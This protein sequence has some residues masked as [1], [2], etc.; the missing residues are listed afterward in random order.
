MNMQRTEAQAA[1]HHLKILY[2]L[3]LSMEVR[4]QV[5]GSYTLPIMYVCES[6]TVDKD[7]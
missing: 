7:S 4:T 6:W 1:S 3:P 2:N 5:V